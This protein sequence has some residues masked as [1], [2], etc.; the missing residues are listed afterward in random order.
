MPFLVASLL[1]ALAA[2]ALAWREPTFSGPRMVMAVLA[3]LLAHAATNLSNDYFDFRAGNFPKR[4]TG[5]T[6]GSFAIQHGHFSPEQILTLA[7]ACFAAALAL[8]ASL[9]SSGSPLLL[10]LGLAGLLIGFFYTAP[11]L[12]LGYRLL[13]EVATLVGMG[14]LLFETVYL[15]TTGAFSLPGLALSAF[16]GLLVLNVL[17]VA[18]IPDIAI[19]ARSR[20]RTLAVWAGPDALR[21]AYLACA[22]LGALCLVGGVL[23]LGLPAAAL[24][25][26]LGSGLSMQAHR[27]LTAQRPFEAFGQ[28]IEAL[29]VGGGLVVAA[30]VLIP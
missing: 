23:A 15:A 26:L 16:M 20:K 7:L 22:L 18:Q 5:P 28:T 9:A 24:I 19:D 27:H 4:K 1:P 13:G 8:F 14:P 30:L 25:G 17:L 11:P 29:Q 2:G 12:R 10:P 21:Q 3:V 6:G